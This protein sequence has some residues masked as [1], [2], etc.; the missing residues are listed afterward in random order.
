M[1][2]EGA[3]RRD[4]GLRGSRWATARLTAG[5]TARSGAAWGVVFGGY[6]AVQALAY[7][8]SYPTVAS[9]RK[10]EAEFGSSPGIS[11]LVGPAHSL[12]TVGGYTVWK[13]LTALAIGGAVWGL[14]LATKLV[15]GEEEAGRSELLLSGPTT[16]RRFTIQ[17]V[18][19]LAAG[20]LA[21]FVT[22]SL[23]VLAAGHS[24]KLRFGVGASLY[25]A[26][27]AV[28]GAVMFLAVGAL[29]SQLVATRRQAASYCAA[30]LAA[31]YAIRMVA[32][33]GTGLTW[34]RWLSP[35][36]WIEQL[37]PFARPDPVALVPI[38]AIVGCSFGAAIWLGGRRDLG[39]S[40]L[41]DHSSAKARLGLLGGPVALELR[42]QRGVLVSWA[43][44]ICAYGLL[45]GGIA[46][47]AGQA[48]VSSPTLRAVFARLGVTGPEAF[49]GFA[50]LIVAVLLGFVAAGQVNA[51]RLEE[52]SNRLELFLVRR[53]SR[54]AW[55]T[56][57]AGTCATV[58]V[59][60]ALLGGV[61]VWAGSAMASAGIPFATLV[62]A[63][64]NVAPPAIVVAAFGLL[65]FGVRPRST[66]FVTYGLLSWSLLVE[67]L[68]GVA[69]VNHWLLDSSVLHQMAPAPG[70]PV[71]WSVDGVMVLVA[72]TAT[73][74]GVA[75]FA[76]RD[77]AG[78]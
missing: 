6:V 42:L 12:T 43:L 33:A 4:R 14:L 20:P 27:A 45:L 74:I 69:H 31:G 21:L 58:L 2:T 76:R 9:R 53:T 47:S 24:S 59:V 62:R 55:M 68:S 52:S 36:G 72:I 56:G 30:F 60:G 67:L 32:D 10:L 15:R 73:L 66:A 49:L 57:R 16:R 26:V 18:L 75:S 61:S 65:A 19:G 48:I 7:A 11:A 35:L 71:D 77:L 39:G 8:T 23:L 54:I 37:R 1:R 51:A 34:L 22:T 3:A 13:C 50:L 64:V 17:R 41:P 78:E 25:F 46:K 29:A 70:A 5:R 28:G 38:V 44:A 63:G 40:L